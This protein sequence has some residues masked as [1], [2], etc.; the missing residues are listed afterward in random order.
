M[1][2]SIR[3]A[4]MRS[5]TNVERAFLIKSLATGI[6]LDG[7]KPHEFRNMTFEF[8]E[9]QRGLVTVRLGRT[10]VLAVVTATVIRPYP[11][12]PA[13]G[14]VSYHVQLSCSPDAL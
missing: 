5:V 14:T 12:R 4:V 13:E 6:R 10:L 1:S 2:E 8:D 7:R 11:D 9:E 3:S